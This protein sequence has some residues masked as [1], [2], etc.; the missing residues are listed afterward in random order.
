VTRQYDDGKGITY[1][2][3]QVVLNRGGKLMVVVGMKYL[4][5][6]CNRV[7]TGPSL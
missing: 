6:T 4:I 3:I 7:K 5:V 2:V 1:R